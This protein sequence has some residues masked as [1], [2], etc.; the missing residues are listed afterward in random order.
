[1]MLEMFG[2]KEL[3]TTKIMSFGG[4]LFLTMNLIE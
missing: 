4:V 2:T 1:M 3:R